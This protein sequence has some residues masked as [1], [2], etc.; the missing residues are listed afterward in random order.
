MPS[1]PR[2]SS[3]DRQLAF[4]QVCERLGVPSTL[5]RLEQ[6][7]VHPSFRNEA[8]AEVGL[9]NQRLE[10]L[11]DAVLALCVSELLMAE[12]PAVDEGELTVMRAALVNAEALA[13]VAARLELGAALRLGRGADATGERQRP[14]VLAD[15]LEAVVG[16]VYLDGGLEAARALTRIVVADGVATLQAQGGSERDPKSRL[17]ERLQA[18][19][20]PA[21]S[22][23]VV[24]IDGPAHQRSF[25]VAV[26]VEREPGVPVVAGRGLGRSKKLA[27]QAAAHAALAWLAS[28]EDEPW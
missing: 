20:A 17:Q 23:E 9:D 28:E 18:R 19:G 2:T 21:P 8:G 16:A 6:A 11:G 13:A 4:V 22:Y 10:F 5:P 1:H 15:A 27:A 26:S 24:A 25:E 12:F 14:N 7:L 3:H